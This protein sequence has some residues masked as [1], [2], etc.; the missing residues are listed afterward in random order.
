MLYGIAADAVL[1]IHLL[2]VLFVVAGA[3]L[4]L[5]KRWVAWLHVP[6]AAWGIF[7]ELTGRICPLTTLE[8]AWLR[9]AG[10]DGYSDSFVQHYLL[11]I[12][13]PPGLTRNSQ[14]WIAALVALVNAAV[15]GW[16]LYQAWQRRRTELPHSR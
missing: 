1:V 2:F 10:L 9:Q 16:V 15:Y 12:I 5:R 13:Y 4:V 7:V 8:N 3:F 14:F 11:P 6:A